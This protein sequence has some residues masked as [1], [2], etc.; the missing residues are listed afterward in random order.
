MRWPYTTD[1]SS[2][3]GAIKLKDFEQRHEH[4]GPARAAKTT[5][6]L[7][8]QEG[9]WAAGLKR[10][11]GER[12]REDGVVSCWERRRQAGGG[13]G[14][15]GE[16]RI[17]ERDPR[18]ACASDETARACCALR[19]FCCVLRFERCV[20]RVAYALLVVCADVHDG[21]RARVRV[22]GAMRA[23]ACVGSERASFSA[24][25]SFNA[26]SSRALARAISV[27]SSSMAAARRSARSARNF[28]FTWAD[29]PN[30]EMADI[31][32][33]FKLSASHYPPNIPTVR[34]VDMNLLSA[35]LCSTD[36]TFFL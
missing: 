12:G 18:A 1:I 5:K 25:L 16:Q 3:R 20:L 33:L 6:E 2:R 36:E 11:I 9:K 32:G 35:L 15:E 29:H 31:N 24:I 10:G 28:S 27:I 21:V 34:I 13:R 14:L 23:R 8:L 30:K 17:G 26:A 19:V 7:R 4:G 22:S